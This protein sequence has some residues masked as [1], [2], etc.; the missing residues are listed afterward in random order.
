VLLICLLCLAQVLGVCESRF[1]TST[2]WVSNYAFLEPGIGTYAGHLVALASKHL[3]VATAAP[4][5]YL[6]VQ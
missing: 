2:R 6:T 1:E 5:A 3:S 4:V